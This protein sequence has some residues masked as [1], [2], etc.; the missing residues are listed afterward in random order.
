MAEQDKSNG[1]IDRRS[2]LKVMG[3]AGASA[4]FVSVA[5]PPSLGT[6]FSAKP[7][8]QPNN[9]PPAITEKAGEILARQP[10]EKLADILSK[11]QLARKWETTMKDLFMSGK[12]DLYGAYHLYVGQEAV[13]VGVCAALN[14]D[15]YITSTHRG[16]GHVIA[17]GGDLNK[18]S[19][20]IYFR[21][22]G[23]NKGFGGSMHITDVSLGILGANG[24][25]GPGYYIAPGAAYGIKVRGTKQVAVSFAG[26]GA[27]NSV[28][29]FSGLRSAVTYKL[30]YVAV[31]E[32]N[33]YQIATPMITNVPG[34]QLSNYVKGLAIPAV[35]ID[36]NDV[37][38]VFA[39]TQEA[40]ERA[41]A[42]FGPS[43]IECMTYRWYDHYGFAGAKAGA[44]GAFGLPYRPD[45]EVK[46]WMAN[47]PIPRYKEFLLERK[48]L[49][50]SE[51][52]K[53]DADAQKTVD[54]S[55]EF[56]RKSPKV[57]PEDGLTNVYAKGSVA[58]TQFFNSI[59][60]TAFQQGPDMVIAGRNNVPL[61]A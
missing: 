38:A 52:D 20:E 18:M 13:A 28:Y 50:Q 36:G 39:A 29:F 60:P 6:L 34:G 42:G 3:A 35:T 19:A 32:N 17:K 47:D 55:I 24:I 54:A 9:A 7:P 41:R 23:Y 57:K 22:D 11:L 43:L 51:I 12:D 25:L 14:K 49:T 26:D 56:A 4:A 48:L 44:D 16:H 61:M 8:V 53:I 5:K 30:P 2:F 33:L 59:A 46:Y 10:K 21:Q 58:A 15:D 37:A 40:V 45:S 27:T 31:V 1:K